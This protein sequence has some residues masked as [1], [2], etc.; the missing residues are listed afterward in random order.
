MLRPPVVPADLTETAGSHSRPAAGGE[1]RSAA[2]GHDPVDAP[3]H[4]HV[5]HRAL[6]GHQVDH[7][8]HGASAAAMLTVGTDRVGRAILVHLCLRAAGGDA[9][10]GVGQN[11]DRPVLVEHS[12]HDHLHEHHPEYVCDRGI[13]FSLSCPDQAGLQGDGQV[14]GQHPSR[15]GQDLRRAQLHRW[16]LGCL[17]LALL[18]PALGDHAGPRSPSALD[19]RVCGHGHHVDPLE[20]AD[21]KDLAQGLRESL[22]ERQGGRPAAPVAVPVLLLGCLGLEQ[23]ALPEHGGAGRDA[24]QD[25]E[26]Q[27]DHCGPVPERALDRQIHVSSRVEVVRLKLSLALAEQVPGLHAVARVLAGDSGRDLDLG[28]GLLQRQ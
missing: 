12:R 7:P 22:S 23:P 13:L 28:E 26:Q 8:L 2:L 19:C 15:P 24:L 20:G 27:G 6:A 10:R 14:A 4:L 3:H 18:L 5:H 9:H 16:S 17:V 25:D 1:P 21:R 11:P